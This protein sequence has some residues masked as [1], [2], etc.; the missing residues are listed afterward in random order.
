MG[1]DGIVRPCRI[2]YVLWFTWAIQLWLLSA[3]SQRSF[4]GG[5]YAN[6]EN[7]QQQTSV[8]LTFPK[9]KALK[10]SLSGEF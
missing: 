10:T 6:D 7:I 3:E 1:M 4:A 9:K 8:E 5:E 2:L